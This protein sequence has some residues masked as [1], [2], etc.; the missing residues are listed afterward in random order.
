MKV[1][2]IG[3]TGNISGACS[4]LALARGIDLWLLTRGQRTGVPAGAKTLAADIHDTQ[5]AAT[6]L[7]GHDW[8]AV[9]NFIAYTVEDVERDLA[10]FAGRTRQYVFISS[11]S[12][13]QKPLQRPVITEETPL[14]NPYWEYSRRKI[15]CEERLN[16]AVRDTGFPAVIVRPSLT[17][18]TVIPLMGSWTDW[19]MVDRMR[20]GKPV[21]V[22]GDGS[23]LWTVTHA[24]DFAKGFVPLLGN[25]A[26]PGQAFHITS[27]EL[28]TWNQIW[29]ATAEAAGCEARIVHVATD[30][31]VSVEPQLTGG[32]LGDKA[33]SMIFDNRKIKRFVPG[34][35]ATIPYREGIARTIA[36]FEADPTRQ[37][38]V[39]ANNALHDR[40]LAAYR[41]ATGSQS[42]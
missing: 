9:V 11:A 20:R 17:Y 39:D 36:G 38:I 14:A 12:V 16:Q 8:D 19:T 42:A 4:R 28:L 37:R 33:V 1:L 24:D 26:T 30:F 15:A 7:A 2:F 35:R 22:H 31:I 29:Q 32:L 21:V 13:Y 25:A 40:I 3:G 6:A 23:S 5:A 27:D 18:D 34:F 10:L 41:S